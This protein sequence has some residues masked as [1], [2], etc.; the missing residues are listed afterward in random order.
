MLVAVLK[1]T[2]IS[3]PAP[4]YNSK[5]RLA[6]YIIYNFIIISIQTP[7]IINNRATLFIYVHTRATIIYAVHLS[8]NWQYQHYAGTQII[9]TPVSNFIMKIILRR[10]TTNWTGNHG[11]WKFNQSIKWN[12]YICSLV[13]TE[14]YLHFSNIIIHKLVHSFRFIRN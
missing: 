12:Y 11:M 14:I 6:K 5:I 13:Q 2:T 10:T 7:S 4:G 9:T 1:Y 3:L 8:F